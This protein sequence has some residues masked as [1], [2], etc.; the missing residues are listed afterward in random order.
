MRW[1]S[2][3]SVEDDEYGLDD[4]VPDEEEDVDDELWSFCLSQLEAVVDSRHTQVA[5]P[6]EASDRDTV[7]ESQQTFLLCLR[8][9][10]C[11]LNAQQRRSTHSFF[12]SFPE[13]LQL[14]LKKPNHQLSVNDIGFNCLKSPYCILPDGTKVS[15]AAMTR[16][17]STR[18]SSIIQYESRS[19]T[20][21][22]FGMVLFFFEYIDDEKAMK[23][24]RERKVSGSYKYRYNSSCELAYIQHFPHARMEGPGDGLCYKTASMLG[25]KDVFLVINASSIVQ[26]VGVVQNDGKEFFTGRYSSFF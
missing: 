18:N 14:T 7:G 6:Q 11:K 25:D 13:L 8:K 15:S 12:L 19:K 9:K 23:E 4:S 3:Q 26:L 16:A 5:K 24:L 10:L 21:R 1:P 20:S 2:K 17:N 22:H